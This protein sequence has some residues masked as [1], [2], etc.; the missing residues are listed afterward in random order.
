MQ[1]R[2]GLIGGKNEA[3]TCNVCDQ[4]HQWELIEYSRRRRH[5]AW[6]TL[7]DKELSVFKE[8]REIQIWKWEIILGWPMP[9]ILAFGKDIFL[10]MYYYY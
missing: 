10:K 3:T 2:K 7:C 1:V 8:Q 5:Q 6:K 4:P 9:F